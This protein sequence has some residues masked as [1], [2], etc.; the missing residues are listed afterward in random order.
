M[1]I[2]ISIRTFFI[3]ASYQI[4]KNYLIL[5]NHGLLF[6]EKHS[7]RLKLF[8]LENWKRLGC[9]SSTKIR[10]QAKIDNFAFK[11]SNIIMEE[12]FWKRKDYIPWKNLKCRKIMHLINCNFTWTFFL[13]TSYEILKKDVILINHGSFF[14]EKE[15]LQLY[16]SQFLEINSLMAETIKN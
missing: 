5:I 15:S 14:E 9:S 2:F 13:I 4:L 16:R 1:K 3:I 12:L 11:N 8:I 7:L 6:Q 10:P